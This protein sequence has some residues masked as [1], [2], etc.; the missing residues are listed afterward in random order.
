VL[1]TAVLNLLRGSGRRGLTSLR[2]THGIVRPLL[3]YDK[4]TIRDYAQIHALQWHEDPTNA[5]MRYLRNHIRHQ[6]LPK[7]SAGERAQLLILLERLREIDAELET[8]LTTLLHVQPRLHELNRRWFIDLPHDVAAEVL[9]AWLRR[10]QV[11]Q[12]SRRR[13]EQLLVAM[14]TGKIGKRIDVD[15]RHK[16]EIK[17]NV[18]ALHTAER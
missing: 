10:H 8:H 11:K 3:D 14:K 16:L 5:D 4:S 9:H 1:E 15:K 18:L 2:S 6:L 13:I 12:P 7:F 17:R